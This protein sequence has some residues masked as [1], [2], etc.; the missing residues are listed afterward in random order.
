MTGLLKTKLPAVMRRSLCVRI[1]M[2][3]Q[4]KHSVASTLRD[5]LGVTLATSII[6]TIIMTKAINPTTMMWFSLMRCMRSSR[7]RFTP[8]YKN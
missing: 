8:K 7:V 2:A 1:R 5:I 3:L 4:G 6:I